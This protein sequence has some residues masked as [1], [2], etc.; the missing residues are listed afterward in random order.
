MNYEELSHFNQQLAAMLSSGLPLEGALR[1]IADSMHRGDLRIEIEAL[2]K[3]LAEGVP[4]DE[5]VGRRKFP[6]L[7]VSLVRVGVKSNDL[8]GALTM[9]ADYYRRLDT[10]WTRL[11]G[12]LVYPGI[13][14]ITALGVSMGMAMLYSYIANEAIQEFGGI[15]FSSRV[16]SARLMVQL[17]LPVVVLSLVV[18]AFFIAIANRRLR[19]SLRWRL[20]GF[21]EASLAQLASAIAVMLENGCDTKTALQLVENAE[22][23][24]AARGELA[25]WRE[26]VAGGTRRFVDV[27]RG[28]LVPRLF[29]WLV[30]SSGENWAA[31]F[32]RAAEV[33]SARANYRIELALYAA[34]PVSILLVTAFVA[35]ELA[36]VVASFVQLM[37]AIGGDFE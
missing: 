22:Q 20:P 23:N 34:L 16:S 33:Y 17:W 11:K 24:R 12:L 32:R 3:D 4:L 9:L 6:E 14:L 10:T 8:P 26:R 25:R 30:A 7:Y 31:G 5:A 1:E 15:G 27:A 37:N 19:H 29:V 2:E 35:T 28:T 36:P 13:V 21:R 18:L